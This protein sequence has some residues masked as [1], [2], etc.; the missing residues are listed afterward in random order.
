VIL[1]IVEKSGY[2]ERIKWGIKQYFGNE[3]QTHQENEIESLKWKSMK[4]ELILNTKI[5]GFIEKY[6]KLSKISKAEF[7]AS[8]ILARLDCIRA[9]PEII[10]DYI[11][12]NGKFF[13]D[14]KEGL[15]EYY[16][17]LIY[18]KG[19]HQNGGTRNDGAK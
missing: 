10:L 9:C 6:C 4:L 13:E 12:N 16:R 5:I 3:I 8:L 17:R 1:S 19:K 15:K 11:K 18:M 7:I 14:L 2:L